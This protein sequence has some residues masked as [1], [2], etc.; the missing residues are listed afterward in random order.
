[1]MQKRNFENYKTRHEAYLAYENL[2]HPPYWF[3]DD[4]IP[5]FIVVDFCEW[6]WLPVREDGKYN[7]EDKKQYLTGE[8]DE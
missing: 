1:M 4:G 5:A 2:P 6:I 3:E 8:D 7:K